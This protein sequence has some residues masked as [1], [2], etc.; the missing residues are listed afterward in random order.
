MALQPFV[1]PW[2]LLQ[3]RKIFFIQTVGLLGRGI[4][5]SQ[6]RYL[7]PEEHKDR[8]N[9]HTDIRFEPTISAFERA[10]T[11]HVLDRAATVIGN[12]T[13]KQIYTYPPFISPT[14][15]AG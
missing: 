12:F 7:Y 6:G 13:S 5:L 10:K 2:P 11:A 15:E 14:Y 9:R 3:F 4:S 8:I 1:R